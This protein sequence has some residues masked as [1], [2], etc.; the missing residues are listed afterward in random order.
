MLHCTSRLTHA[1]SEQAQESK[2]SM[3]TCSQGSHDD[4][5]QEGCESANHS[6]EPWQCDND[7]DGQSGHLLQQVLSFASLLKC[8]HNSQDWSM[9]SEG[10]CQVLA[11][12]AVVRMEI[13]CGGRGGVGT[14]CAPEGVVVISP[15]VG[16]SMFQAKKAALRPGQVA[17]DGLGWMDPGIHVVI[18]IKVSWRAARLVQIAHRKF[19][20]CILCIGHLEMLLYSN[21]HISQLLV[22]P[23]A[24]QEWIPKVHRLRVHSHV[25]LRQ[26]PLMVKKAIQNCDTPGISPQKEDPIC[27]SCR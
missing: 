7:W 17:A 13:G 18:R 19:P 10:V 12:E 4:G 22:W 15:G 21:L 25:D 6:E 5:F 26:G 23:Q 27:P 3:E 2:A 20:G 14:W 9:G 24:L 16:V 8:G 1:A 11:Q